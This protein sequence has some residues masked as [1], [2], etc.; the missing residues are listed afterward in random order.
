MELPERK[1][2]ILKAIV[3]NY[4]D[5][6]EPVGSKALVNSFD[7][8]ISSATIRNEMSELEDL[9]YLEKPHVSAGRVPSFAAYRLYVNELMDRHR[10]ATN[11]LEAMRI[12]MEAK[13]K[14]IDNIVVS[15]SKVIGEMTQHTAV[16]MISRKGED[17]VKRCELIAIDGGSTYAA[18]LITESDVKNKMLRLEEPVEPAT[19]AML[20]TALNLAVSERR[21]E[22]VL[23]SVAQSMGSDSQVYRMTA[24]ILDFIRQTEAGGKPEVYIDGTARLLDNREYQDTG[25]ARELLEY[26]SDRSKVGELLETADGNP[27]NVRIGPELRDPSMR[28]ASLVF[29]SYDIDRNTKGIVGI[30]APARMDYADVCAKLTA[31]TQAVSHVMGHQTKQL[32]D[33][34]DTDERREEQGK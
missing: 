16:S 13:M 32:K 6:A 14:E 28:D 19:A 29:T 4:I 27:I 22:L 18:V 7:T 30:I 2:R 31:F 24:D 17:H 1:R 33:A 26:F 9:G 3:E 15:A 12:M 21:L 34:G 5:T 25:R 10:V 11:E 8:P 23:P 20:C